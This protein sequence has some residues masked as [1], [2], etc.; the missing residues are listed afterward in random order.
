MIVDFHVHTAASPDSGIDPIRL[1]EKARKAGLDGVA[2]CDHDTVEG[3][4][5]LASAPDLLVIVAE[6]VKTTE[7]EIIGYFLTRSIPGGLTPEETVAEILAQDG[8]VCVPH[9]FDRYRRSPLSLEALERIAGQVDAIEGL[10]GRNLSSSDDDAARLWAAERG[11]PVLAGSDAH[12][13]GEIGRATTRLPAF[14]S[15]QSLRA[16]LGSAT[17]EGGHSNPGVHL[18]TAVR[19]RAA[20]VLATRRR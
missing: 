19:K 10:N 17:L 4:L 14:D 8:L 20:R 18:L 7:G 3:A 5:A 13:Y 12:T 1:I 15:A 6:E 11:I 2:V 9:P 16:A